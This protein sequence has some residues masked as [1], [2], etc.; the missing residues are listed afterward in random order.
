MH[1][2]A[3]TKGRGQGNVHSMQGVTTQPSHL[4]PTDTSSSDV[5]EDVTRAQCNTQHTLSPVLS[6]LLALLKISS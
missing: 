6:P 5:L 3:I 1:V 2:I 4:S